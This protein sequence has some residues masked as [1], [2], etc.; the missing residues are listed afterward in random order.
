MGLFL[1]KR[2]EFDGVLDGLIYGAL[3]GFGFAMTENFLYFVGAYD[4]GGFAGLSWVIVL[5][6]I[7]FGLNHAFYTSL[8]GIGFGLA[9]NQRSTAAKVLLAGSGLAA[10][11]LVHALHN[12][13]ATVAGITPLGFLLSLL[14]AGGGSGLIVA[15]VVLSWN[16][17]R[18]VMQ[19][20]LTEELGNVL[21]TQDLIELTGRWR[22]PIRRRSGDGAERMALFAELA[23]RKRRVRMLGSTHSADTL[24]E[25]EEIRDR[26][27]E[28]GAGPA[29]RPALLSL[30][31]PSCFRPTTASPDR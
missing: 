12:L 7:L 11:I 25:I 1:W 13:G 18:S 26:L 29:W 14:V 21:S 28:L 22:Q 17:E 23:V 4:E 9:R 30:K 31:R 8:T 19:T 16:H 5:R 24:A 15:A 2:N 6:A 27:K 3:I 10:A 20:E